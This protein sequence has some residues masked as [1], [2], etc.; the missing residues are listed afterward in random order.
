VPDE[1]ERPIDGYE[2]NL[3]AAKPD[4]A[5][6]LANEGLLLDAVANWIPG[7]DDRA[8]A[9]D[10]LDAQDF[11]SAFAGMFTGKTDLDPG[12]H[13]GL[14]AYAAWRASERP[15][16]ER[17]GALRFA[18][19]T[20]LAVCQSAPTLARLSTLA[21]ATWESGQRGICLLALRSFA[22]LVAQG[23][24][25]VTEPFWSACARFDGLAPGQQ[26]AE[27]LL[28]SAFEQLDRAATFSSQFAAAE[29]DL[30]WLCALPF[31]AVEME[32]RRIL[33]H[34]RAG[35]RVEVPARLCVAADDHLNADVWGAGLVPGTWVRQAAEGR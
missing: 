15:L 33:R 20:L 16:A 12:Y 30:D 17:C 29:F 18:C 10:L 26:R 23:A 4:R 3:F 19:D 28:A 22:Q 27:W 34:A 9:L 31:A 24:M 5:A 21:R 35:E 2:L 25:N 13:A 32:R 14:A 7:S 11:A 8:K 6:A 1:P